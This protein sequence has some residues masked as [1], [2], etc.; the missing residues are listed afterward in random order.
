MAATLAVTVAVAGTSA[1][2]VALTFA[3]LTTTLVAGLAAVM[4]VPV[5]LAVAALFN[6]SVDA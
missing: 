1:V 2:S 5:P 4:S 6:D 3:V